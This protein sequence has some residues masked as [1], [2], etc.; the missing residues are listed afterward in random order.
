[1]T[2]AQYQ[3]IAQLQSELNWPVFSTEVIGMGLAGSPVIVEFIWHLGTNNITHKVLITS[4]GRV[5]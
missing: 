3:A 4:D 5:I 2:D 1:M